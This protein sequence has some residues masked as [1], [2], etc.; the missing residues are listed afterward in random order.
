MRRQLGTEGSNPLPSSGESSANLRELASTCGYRCAKLPHDVARLQGAH[1]DDRED[2][3]IRREPGLSRPHL[4]RPDKDA[5][6]RR[7]NVRR[8]RRPKVNPTYDV[9]SATACSRIRQGEEHRWTASIE[10]TPRSRTKPRIHRQRGHRR[11]V[12]ACCGC[13][14]R[15]IRG[16][17]SPAAV[18]SAGSARTPREEKPS[19][20]VGGLALM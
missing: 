6:H 16:S 1:P 4:L 18:T 8:D 5:R 12:C 14:R 15:R 9:L 13:W 7:A 17:A 11:G 20:C 2:H 19:D 3:A 10:G